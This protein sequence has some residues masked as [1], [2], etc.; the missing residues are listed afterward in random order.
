MGQPVL[1]RIEEPPA[2]RNRLTAAFRPIL[3]IPHALLVGGPFIGAGAGRGNSGALGLV[4]LTAAII[5]WFAIVFTGRH[6]QGLQGLKRLYLRWRARFLAYVCL[7]RDEYPP[8]GD[9]IYPATLELPVEP[10]VRDRK[11]VG[12]RLLLAVPHILIVLGLMLAEVV[13]AIVSWACILVTGRLPDG[14]WRFSRDVIAYA[15]RVE[16]YMLLVHDEY[17]PFVFA[18]TAAPIGAE[19]HASAKS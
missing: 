11:S 10:A 7:L 8:F 12:L 3:A 2:P 16:T 4:A 5:D 17:P 13:V 18:E 6:I 14:L 19:A 9:G 15:M 1:F